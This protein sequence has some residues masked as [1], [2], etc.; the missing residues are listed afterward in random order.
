MVLVMHCMLVVP[1]VINAFDGVGAPSGILWL[2]TFTP[3]HI[4]WAGTEAVFIFFVLSGFVLT[5]ATDNLRFSWRAY[6]PARLL[7]LYLPVAAALVFT[8]LVVTVVPVRRPHSAS[9][10]LLA[11][12]QTTP[13]LRFFAH[14]L[15]L[16]RGAGVLA[17]LWSLKW[18]VIFSLALPIV[19]L[20]A[21]RRWQTGLAQAVLLFG[22]MLLGSDSQAGHRGYL[23]H[24]PMFGVGAI[25]AHQHQ[26]LAAIGRKLTATTG[27]AAL[28]V[29]IVLL[30]LS[31]TTRDLSTE[32]YRPVA[33]AGAA[34]IVFAFGYWKPLRRIGETRP[35]QWLGVRSF[36]LYLVHFPIVISTAILLGSLSR[37]AFVIAIPLSLLCAHI[38][39]RVAEGPSH[40]FSQAIKKRLTADSGRL[41]PAPAAQR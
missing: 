11:Q 15:V 18:E 32:A 7:R 25:M 5:R 6:Y 9:W 14:S 17:P 19:L 30:T 24:L 22:V 8:A 21:H 36:S 26:L 28:G 41:R 34:L 13:S 3:A 2:V 35:L 33:V 37:Y 10:W 1:S 29:G 27:A 23:L 38:F 31:W 12:Q 16:V 4:F 39:F 20:G 40:R